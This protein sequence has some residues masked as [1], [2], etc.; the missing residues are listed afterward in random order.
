[1]EFAFEFPKKVHKSLKRESLCCLTFEFVM[2]I[3]PEIYVISLNWDK[4]KKKKV[5]IRQKYCRL[6]W[7]KLRF[8]KKT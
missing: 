4:K 5:D 7:K 3:L 2:L 1:M 8:I 6:I